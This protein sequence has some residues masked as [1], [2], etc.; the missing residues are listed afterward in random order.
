MRHSC[1][2]HLCLSPMFCAVEPGADLFCPLQC[3]ARCGTQGTMKRE[4][5]C[6]V[7]ASLC[8]E[9]QKPSSEKACTGPPCDRRW[10]ASDWGPVSPEG[11][12]LLAA[13]AGRR[14]QGLSHATALFWQRLNCTS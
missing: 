7:E 5:R 2:P 3:S 13:N 14:E 11:L 6:S 12:L 9:S 4:V 1:L 8:D 10:T